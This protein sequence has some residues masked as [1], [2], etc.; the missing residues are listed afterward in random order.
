[1]VIL[2]YP[3]LDSFHEDLLLCKPLSSTSTGT[4]IYK[5]LDEFFVENSI[6]WDNCVDVCTDGA[7]AMTGNMSGAI[8]KI[9]EKPRGAAA[10]TAHFINMLLQ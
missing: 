10:S 7:K 1:M 2:L 8:S 3:Y 5:L 9:K 6:L 4:E